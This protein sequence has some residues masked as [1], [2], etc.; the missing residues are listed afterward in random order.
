MDIPFARVL[1]A[2]TKGSMCLLGFLLKYIFKNSNVFVLVHYSLY[3]NAYIVHN[4]DVF[5]LCV[6]VLFMAH[7][8]NAKVGVRIEV[9]VSR[10]HL[11]RVKELGHLAPPRAAGQAGGVRRVRRAGRPVCM[12]D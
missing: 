7:L 12:L 1:T 10:R 4:S 3:I 6:I 2:R 8:M 9:V 5:F 11:L